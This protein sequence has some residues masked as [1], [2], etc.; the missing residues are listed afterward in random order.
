LTKAV[1]G[2]LFTN[3]SNADFEFSRPISST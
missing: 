1:F 3:W 2:A